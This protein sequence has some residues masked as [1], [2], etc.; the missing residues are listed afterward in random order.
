MEKVKN[1]LPPITSF[2]VKNDLGQKRKKP[3]HDFIDEM[4]GEDDPND[5]FKSKRSKQNELSND[6]SIENHK[7]SLKKSENITPNLSV[8]K[9]NS[10]IYRKTGNF[11]VKVSPALCL[12]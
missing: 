7:S 4:L 11:V 5:T 6:F 3:E 2:E 9:V 1:M 12:Y 8:S 10:D